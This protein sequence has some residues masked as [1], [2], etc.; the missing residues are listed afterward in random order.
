ME[1]RD[2][3]VHALAGLAGV[4]VRTL[5]H[6]D[7]IGLLKPASRT[8]AGYRLYGRNELLRLQ[9]ILLYRELELPLDRIAA[10]MDAPGGDSADA[11]EGHRTL[12]LERAARIEA[13]IK[14]VD[15]T[16]A[17]L[18][19]ETMLTDEELYEGFPKDK[20]ESVK[21]ETEELWG[22]TEAYRQSRKRVA[23][24][25]REEFRAVGAR[26]AGIEQKFA[27]LFAAGA[28]PDS[29]E[30]S[31]N[32]GRFAEHLRAFYDPSPEMI[33]GLGEM[34]VAHPDFRARYEAMAPGLPEYLRDAFA[35][36]AKSPDSRAA[37]PSR[38]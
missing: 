31:A 26:G 22:H 36:W 24:M 38:A 32:V 5:H 11:L 27:E 10:L 23:A 28:A 2:Y 16:L 17:H 34:Y 12:L 30:V 6:Y 14:T 13:L 37:A 8:S 7:S 1:D 19:G 35:A 15:R 18:R 9:R 25:T 21:R 4:S 20:V 29:P 33:A 3:T